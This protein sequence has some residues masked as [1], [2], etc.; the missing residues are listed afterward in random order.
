MFTLASR[1]LLI[2]G[3]YVAEDDNSE[4]WKTHPR[5]T[6]GCQ[7]FKSRNKETGRGG[8][9]KRGQGKKQ[10]GNIEESGGNWNW[11]RKNEDEN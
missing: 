3:N 11:T 8:G 5:R 6:D 7:N 1:G 9:R 2:Q 4:L 10:E